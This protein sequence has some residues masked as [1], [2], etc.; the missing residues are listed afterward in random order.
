MFNSLSNMKLRPATLS[1]AVAI[2]ALHAASWRSTYASVLRAEYLTDIVPTER[3]RLW[4]ERLTSPKANQYV[5]VAEAQG[6]ILG[7]ACVFAEEH[8]AWGAYL[9]NLHVETTSQGKGVGRALI[10]EVARWCEAHHP[11]RGLYLS[12]NQDNLRAQRFY[13]GFG[14]RN[15]ESSVWHAPEGSQVPT[16]R[17]V[18]DS[19]ARLADEARPAIG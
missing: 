8:D 10:A 3:R 16:F 17:F 15:A 7:F 12:V 14:A 19:A 4:M 5:V 13:L 6:S 11:G 2:A 1:D 18:W 9:E